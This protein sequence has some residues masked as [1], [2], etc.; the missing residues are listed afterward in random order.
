MCGEGGGCQWTFRQSVIENIFGGLCLIAR[1]DPVDSR[2][3]RT[4][5]ET[6]PALQSALVLPRKPGCEAIPERLAAI[7]YKACLRVI[8]SQ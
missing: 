1:P 2:R 6:D 5:N 8:K 7:R 3:Q 4:R